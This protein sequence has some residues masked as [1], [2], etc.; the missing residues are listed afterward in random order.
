[1]YDDVERLIDQLRDRDKYVRGNATVALGRI[2]DTR[3][4]EPLIKA[5]EDEDSGVRWTAAVALGKIG[6]H[7]THAFFR[8]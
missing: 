7:L 5:L 6:W 3:A 2:G 1:M 4:V 8:L